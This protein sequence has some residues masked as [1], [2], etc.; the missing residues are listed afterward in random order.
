MGTSQERVNQKKGK[1]CK[2]GDRQLAVVWCPRRECQGDCGFVF[3]LIACGTVHAEPADLPFR[4]SQAE[5]SALTV[6][7]S[8]LNWYCDVCVFVCVRVCVRVRLPKQ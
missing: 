7:L 5:T 2:V 3:L 1:R 4:T 8:P 6:I